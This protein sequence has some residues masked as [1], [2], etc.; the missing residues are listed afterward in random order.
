MP[1]AKTAYVHTR[2]R[3]VANL[4]NLRKAHRV[5]RTHYRFTAA[6]RAAL[7]KAR[8]ARKFLLTPAKLAALR[9]ATEAN[10]LNFRLTPARLAAMRTN[11]GKM[12]AA[13][14]EKFRL[15]E[16]RLLASRANLRKAQAVE[17]APKSYARSRFNHLKHGL[18][19][20]TLDETLTL[21]GEDPREFQLHRDLLA[22]AFVP[23]DELERKVIHRLAEAVWRRLRLYR[24]QARWEA[25][26]LK[27]HL[28][29]SP[30]LKTLPPE[31][32]RLRAFGLMALL[33]NQDCL[34]RWSD[35]LL[36]RVEHMLRFLLRKR[37]GHEDRE[38]RGLVLERCRVPKE[39]EEMEEHWASERAV[40]R[41]LA[42]GPEVEAILERFRPA[43]QRR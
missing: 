19:V 43:W 7:D 4:A 27:A 42:G 20:R 41:L 39:L 37:L 26:M 18:Q 28:G 8:Q 5:N 33:L 31:L 25:D 9:K 2:R 15:T 32:T 14:V 35:Q 21:L 29:A 38:F 36:R 11:A 17:R 13:S 23:Q 12:Q 34:S 40:Q 1:K 3:L 30:P 16:R 22:R 10:R 24:A 6:R